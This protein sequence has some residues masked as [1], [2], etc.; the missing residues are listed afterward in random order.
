MKRT[1]IIFLLA[2]LLLGGYSCSVQNPL[3]STKADNNKS[4]EV[5]YLFEHDGCKVYRFQDNGHFVYFTN[6]KSD[7]TSIENDST[8]IRVMNA[9][10]IS[11]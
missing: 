10:S 3:A 2:I 1:I 5:Q 6:C 4:Y 9:R 7:V 8:R 11:K